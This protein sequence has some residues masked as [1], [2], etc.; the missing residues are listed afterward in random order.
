MKTRQKRIDVE[1][2]RAIANKL[3]AIPDNGHVNNDFRKGVIAVIEQVLFDSKSY[4]G[5]SHNYWSEIGYNL[6]IDAGKPDFPQK[7]AFI[8]NDLNRC[9]F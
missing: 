8:G 2:V 6:W 4:H 3:L 1:A 7:D 9:Y 5:Y